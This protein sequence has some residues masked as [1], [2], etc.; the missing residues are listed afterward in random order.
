M[1]TM[2]LRD[3]PSTPLDELRRDLEKLGLKSMLAHLDD[4]LEQASQLEQGYASFLAGLVQREV[5]SRGDAS[6]ARRMKTAGFPFS[7]TFDT[8][9][10]TF[11]P[12]LNV[13]Q[14]KDLMNLEFIRQ[15]RALLLMGKPGTGKTHLSIAFGTLAVL[16][17]YTVH[18][19]SAA[20]LLVD[21]YASLAD[22]STDRLIGRLARSDL[23]IIDDIRHVPPR[24]EYATLLFDL[25]EARHLKKSTLVTSNISIRDWGRVLGNPTL[26]ASLVDRLMERAHVVNIKNGRSYRTEGPEAPSEPPEGLD[27]T[28]REDPRL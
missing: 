18:Y 8:F 19:Y 5:L 3:L 14:I 21:L 26:T 11:Q 16:H 25:V 15:G 23:L 12:N 2:T 9:D 10:W 13:L 4:A 28:V 1:T 17:G 27:G 22:A 6:A 20:Q 24:P 7:R